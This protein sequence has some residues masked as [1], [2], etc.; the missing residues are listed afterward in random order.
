M[1]PGSVFSPSPLFSVNSFS[2]FP[3]LTISGTLYPQIGCLACPRLFS[4]GFTSSRKN[5]SAPSTAQIKG[6]TF[7]KSLQW[8]M[9]STAPSMTKSHFVIQKDDL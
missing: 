6:P 4:P 7:K 2:I 9:G 5:E 3:G 1:F 8:A